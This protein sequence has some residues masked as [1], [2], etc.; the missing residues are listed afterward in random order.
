MFDGLRSSYS[1][2]VDTALCNHVRAGPERLARE[3]SAR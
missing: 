3:P 2:H 1:S